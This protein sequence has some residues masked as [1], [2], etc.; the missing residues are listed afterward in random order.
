[1]IAF[2]KS[3]FFTHKLIASVLTAGVIGLVSTTAHAQIQALN[4][5]SDFTGGIPTY[6]ST[7]GW[8]FTLSNAVQVTD[9]G[10]FDIR[11]DGFNNSHTV[12][13]WTSN[14]ALLAETTLGSGASG[15]ADVVSGGGLGAFRY[16]S[17]AP[18][19]LGPGT[20]I[21][22][23]TVRAGD[24]DGVFFSQTTAPT[25]APGITFLQFIDSTN[26]FSFPTISGGNIY[27][28]YNANFRIASPHA[29]ATPEPGEWSLLAAAGVG[30]VGFAKSRRRKK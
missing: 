26:G 30:F 2:G 25:T 23:T 13:L 14:G 19:D 18:L 12:A 16:N 21:V 8:Q 15:S 3:T 17:I 20:Y 9:L 7:Y 1:M 27:G 11:N 4:F 28:A 24:T 10:A 5:T 6:N 22:G 29:A